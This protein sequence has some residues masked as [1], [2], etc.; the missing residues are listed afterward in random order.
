MTTDCTCTG[1]V[2]EY[3]HTQGA[4]P[5]VSKADLLIISKM[6]TCPVEKRALVRIANEIGRKP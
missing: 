5:E 2:K 6:E 1:E 4:G 3:G